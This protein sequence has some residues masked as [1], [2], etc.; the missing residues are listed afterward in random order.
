MTAT[1]PA[2]TVIVGSGHAGSEAAISLRQNGFGGRIV[3]IG[4]EAG[5]PYQRP[6]LSKGFLTGTVGL[7]ALPIRPAAVYDKA[8]VEM[9]CGVRATRIDPA[10]KSV[11][12]SD[13]DSLNYTHL[14][15]ATGSSARQLQV[16]GLSQHKPINLHYLRSQADAECMREQLEAGKRLVV[17]GGGYIG[18]EV[19]SA[20]Q[21]AGMQVTILEAQSRILAR[22][23]AHEV[24]E[25]YQQV[26]QAAGIDLRTN[27]QLEQ[28]S[29]N[30]E[31]RIEALVTTAGERFAA[32]VVLVGIGAQPNVELAEQAGLDVDNGILVDA[33]ARTSVADIYAIGDC[34][35]QPS[36]LY[37]RRLRLESIPN[38]IEQARAATGNILGK[39]ALAPSLPWFWSD[40]YDLKLQI[41]G[42]SQGYDQVVLRGSRETHSFAAFYLYEGRLIAADCI[43]RQKEFM[44]IKKLVQAGYS[45]SPDALADE[46]VVLKELITG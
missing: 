4:E 40:Q 34:S 45:G 19:A 21:A 42:L 32:D 41:A 5:L 17:V 23:T 24:S 30:A 28:V 7:D 8:D 43:N 39:A 46:T 1:E 2:C 12:L 18:L 25:F 36:A 38:A 27:V 37:G 31:G 14:I 44:A 20:A 29:L 9:R 11:H 33:F 3:L 15:L 6:P 10:T 22:V 13:G 35:N 16:T 26:H